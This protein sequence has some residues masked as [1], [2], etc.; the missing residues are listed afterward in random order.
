[1]GRGLRKCRGKTL[2][3]RG[4]AI[5]NA[6]LGEGVGQVK[7]HRAFADAQLGGNFFIRKPSFN[8]PYQT[9]NDLVCWVYNY[10]GNVANPTACSIPAQGT[11]NDGDVVG[12][13]EKDTVNSSC[14][15]SE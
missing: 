7:F 12:Q 5:F 2:L 8:Q 15:R 1:V 3:D 9:S 10:Y 4:A 11:G 14:V 13:Y 6:Q